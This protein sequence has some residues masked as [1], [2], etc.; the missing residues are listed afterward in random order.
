MS[1]MSQ[2]ELSYY[3]FNHKRLLE[4]FELIMK[5]LLSGASKS[6][7]DIFANKAELKGFYRF[8]E[9]SEVTQT[10][11]LSAHS[12]YLIDQLNQQQACG[13]QQGP[14]Q[15]QRP[16]YHYVLHDTT[17]M[18]CNGYQK[19]GVGYLHDP[20][21]KGIWLHHSLLLNEHFK[22]LGL[23][24]SE[25][26]VREEYGK[27]H[28]RKQKPIQEKESYKWIQGIQKAAAIR[29]VELV[30]VADRESD[31]MHFLQAVLK[32]NQHFVVRSA[33]DRKLWQDHERLF[34]K[35]KAAPGMRVERQLR[36]KNGKFY[37]AECELHYGSVELTKKDSHLRLP[38]QVVYLKEKQG[39]VEWLLL[40]SLP[41]E[42][43]QEALFILD[44]YQ[45]RWLIE[46]YHKCLKTGCLLEQ[47]QVNEADNLFNMIA[48][49]QITAVKLLQLKNL[50][51]QPTHQ[52]GAA[53]AL[54]APQYLTKVEQ[55]ELVEGSPLWLLV[56]IA[57]LGGHQGLKQKGMPGWQ[58]L[59]KGWQFFQVFLQGFAAAQ[60]IHVP[61]PE[62]HNSNQVIVGKP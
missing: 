19:K 53:L 25:Y 10:G 29:Q 60:A 27:K 36:D 1:S 6:F 9:N 18:D 44:I 21:S 22:P 17:S 34:E 59:W 42:S 45:H 40:T 56:L 43:Q 39:A 14:S 7:P 31:V 54:L 46:E 47:R 23:L 33:Q 2:Q 30:H 11:L 16:N 24:D 32:Q 50:N 8:I 48:L 20:H 57:R 38:V 58:T 35:V 12:N 15:K 62:P 55:L 51:W 13:Q 5:R 37:Q 41:V 52:Q 61:Q 4:R 3:D 28:E 49:L 26:I